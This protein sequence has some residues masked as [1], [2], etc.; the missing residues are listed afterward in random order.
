MVQSRTFR[1]NY[2]DMWRRLFCFPLKHQASYPHTS[3]DAFL[4]G[5]APYQDDEY[6]NEAA[7]AAASQV[8]TTPRIPPSKTPAQ[9][10]QPAPSMEKYENAL[11]TSNHGLSASFEAMVNGDGG[12]VPSA[13]LPRVARTIS[14]ASSVVPPTSPGANGAIS[15]S[16]R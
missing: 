14:T 12:I 9:Q 13:V 16:K 6:E 8:P 1:Q 5:Y 11:A 2:T 4:A 7:V 3:T 10:I 15:A